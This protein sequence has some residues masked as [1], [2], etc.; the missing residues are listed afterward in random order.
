MSHYLWVEVCSIIVY[1]QN[2]VP[3]KVLG[4]MTPEEAFIGKKADV[5]HFTIFGSLTYCRILGDTYTKLDQTVERGYFVGYNETSKA[6]RIFI[7]GTRK[8]L[9]DVI[10][11]SWRKRHL[12][13]PEICQ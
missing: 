8:L 4:R 7:L 11:S 1:I 3:H 5:S 9:V 6:Y 13:G 2:R 10:S 12:E